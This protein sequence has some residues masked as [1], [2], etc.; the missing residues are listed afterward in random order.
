MNRLLTITQFMRIHAISRATVYRENK[1]GRLP[2]IKVGRATRIDE[3]DALAWREAL[4][5]SGRVG[6]AI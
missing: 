6:V 3:A 4:V 1:A 2:F 5:S